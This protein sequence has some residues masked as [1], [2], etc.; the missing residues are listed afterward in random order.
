MGLN[1]FVFKLIFHNKYRFLYSIINLLNY[2][3]F[4]FLIYLINKNNIKSYNNIF[5][6]Y[7][8]NK[9][10]IYIVNNFYKT[11]Y[12]WLLIANY[13]DTNM[14]YIKI[15]ISVSPK[16]INNKN[17]ESLYSIINLKKK[18]SILKKNNDYNFLILNYVNNVKNNYENI[19]VVK[20]KK[21][22]NFYNVLDTKNLDLSRR[23]Q[24]FIKNNRFILKS[25]FNIKYYRKFS[26]NKNIIKYCNLKKKDFL[27]SL[28]NRLINILIKSDFFLSTNDCIWFIKNGLVS[29]NFNEA[30]YKSIVKPLDVINISYN[31]YYFNFYKETFNRF[32]NNMYKINLKF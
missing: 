1:F 25:F 30:T 22:K 19:G 5:N 14:N 10:F 12:N 21:I 6:M 18:T 32:L 20:N 28:E 31:N 7:I 27:F 8:L 26:F 24:L 13:N 11:R 16:K 15:N 3:N 29:L 23:I 4:L 17:Y 2:K 9:K